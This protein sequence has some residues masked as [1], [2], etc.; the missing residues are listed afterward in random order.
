MLFRGVD[1]G[2]RGPGFSEQALAR[3]PCAD[4]EIPQSSD[5]QC[6]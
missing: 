1:R 2:I 6:E 5:C 3:A 4:G